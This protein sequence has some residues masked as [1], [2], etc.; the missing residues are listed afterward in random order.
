MFSK[1]EKNI[2]QKHHTRRFGN[3]LI[4]YSCYE[5][6]YWILKVRSDEGAGCVLES[7]RV[8]ENVLGTGLD[9]RT[10]KILTWAFDT[11][12][13]GVHDSFYS[14]LKFAGVANCSRWFQ[15]KC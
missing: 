1:Y 11:N 8:W 3:N 9:I 6:I 2:L 15:K 7:L 10:S 13:Q 5:I 12:S 14:V 4:C